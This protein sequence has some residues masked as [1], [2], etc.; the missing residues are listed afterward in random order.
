[1]VVEAQSCILEPGKGA[2]LMTGNPSPPSQA[3]IRNVLE[4]VVADTTAIL[5]CMGIQ[6]LGHHSLKTRNADLHVHI[7]YS[8]QQ[9]SITYTIG[10]I[11]M[12]LASLLLGKPPP[13]DVIILGVVG[14][15]G[16]FTGNFEVDMTYITICNNKG[17]RRVIV[18]TGTVI[19]DA[20][21]AY[22]LMRPSVD[23]IIVDKVIDAV[24]MYMAC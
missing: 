6:S 12:S 15:D 5:Q 17:F 23:I 2:V 16:G 14:N 13:T 11:Y 24:P 9:L 20:V 18:G 4:L 3:G 7:S 1:M 8:Y 21:R 19:S 10:A 22:A